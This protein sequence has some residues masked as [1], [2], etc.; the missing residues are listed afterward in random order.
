[1]AGVEPAHLSAEQAAHVGVHRRRDAGTGRKVLVGFAVFLGDD[2]IP[3]LLGTQ[4]YRLLRRKLGSDGFLLRRGRSAGG[5]E[6]GNGCQQ[7]GL[8]DHWN[9][10]LS[11]SMYGMASASPDRVFCTRSGSSARNWRE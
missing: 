1:H 4:R 6:G 9:S 10:L 2:E 11:C 5:K 7:Q 8:A 3:A